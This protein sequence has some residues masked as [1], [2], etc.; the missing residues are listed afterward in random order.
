MHLT[1]LNIDN[2]K[3]LQNI[4]LKNLKRVNL[5]YGDMNTGKTTLLNYIEEN[6]DFFIKVSNSDVSSLKKALILESPKNDNS[7]F[8]SM[9][10]KNLL[11]ENNLAHLYYFKEYI[12]RYIAIDFE[13]ESQVNIINKLMNTGDSLKK[14]IY[15]LLMLLNYKDSILMFDNIDNDLNPSLYNTLCFNI[16][17]ISLSNNNQI[18]ITSNNVNFIKELAEV[19]IKYNKDNF[20]AYEIGYTY[21][22]KVLLALEV[23]AELLNYYLIMKIN[24]FEILK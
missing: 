16:K 20:M 23:D 21:H 9:L 10:Y 2:Y 7:I 17:Y 22:T 18:F 11:K 3:I 13:E 19:S 8:I 1:N 15:I 4:K 12:T 14:Y 6:Y 5:I 24:L